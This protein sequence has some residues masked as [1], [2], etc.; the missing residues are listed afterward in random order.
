[1]SYAGCVNENSNFLMQM[2]ITKRHI[3]YYIHQ[4]NGCVSLPSCSVQ[5]PNYTCVFL[6]QYLYLSIRSSVVVHLFA[7]ITAS[8]SPFHISI[9]LWGKLSFFYC[10]TKFLFVIISC[11]VNYPA[12]PFFLNIRCILSVHQFILLQLSL[13]FPFSLQVLSVSFLLIFQI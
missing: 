3:F 6:H 7:I 13:L 4:A 9:L 12:L 5:G 11:P 10:S 2:K 8:F 1:M